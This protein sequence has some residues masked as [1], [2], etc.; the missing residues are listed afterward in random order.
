M[1]ADKLEW[2]VWNAVANGGYCI[3]V[4]KN[5]KGVEPPL[6]SIIVRSIPDAEPKSISFFG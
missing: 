2:L 1:G 3:E 4:D 6:P 5:V